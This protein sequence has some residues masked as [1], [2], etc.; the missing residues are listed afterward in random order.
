MAASRGQQIMLVLLA[1]LSVVRRASSSAAA[2]SAAD[3]VDLLDP[4]VGPLATG[5]SIS[6]AVGF[7]YQLPGFDA[8]ATNHN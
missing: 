3:T 6:K 8:G 1:I 5:T 7:G 4:A 2:L